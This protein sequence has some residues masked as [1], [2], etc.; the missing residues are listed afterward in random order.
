MTIRRVC[1][2]HRISGPIKTVLRR[3]AYPV[4]RGLLFVRAFVFYLPRVA[5]ATDCLAAKKSFNCFLP[6][7]VLR[8]FADDVFVSGSVRTAHPTNGSVCGY[9]RRVRRAHRGITTPN[10][11]IPWLHHYI[12]IA[13]KKTMAS[14]HALPHNK[15]AHIPTVVL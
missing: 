15:P 12:S 6:W 5:H 8:L 2:T 1:R 13:H 4:V 7:R 11:I 10:P 14:I 3:T 9:N